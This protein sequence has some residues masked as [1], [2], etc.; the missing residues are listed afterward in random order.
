KLLGRA[1]AAP[2]APEAVAAALTD[3]LRRELEQVDFFLQQSLA[4]EARSVLDELAE[5]FPG[6]PLI[7]EKRAAVLRAEREAAQEADI[8]GAIPVGVKAAP[9]IQHT[10]VAKL[11]TSE[12]ADPGTHGDLGIAYKQMGLYDAAI[13]EFKL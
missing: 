4:D 1:V 5:R 10:P 11:S 3:E 12:R 8:P 13:A 7:D 9:T 2:P 6:H